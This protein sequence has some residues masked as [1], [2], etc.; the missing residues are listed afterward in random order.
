MFRSRRQ[1]VSG[2]LA[3]GVVSVR[4][5]LGNPLGK[6]IGLQLYM[7]DAELGKDFDG[8][9]KK[10]ARIGIKEVE[11]A[12]TYGK[13]AGEWKAALQKS[14]LHC[15]SVHV[16]D[17][18]QA[19]EDVMKF[20][21]EL[22]ARYVVTSLNAPPAVLAKIPKGAPLDWEHLVHAV[23][24]MTAEDWKKSAGMANEL[25]AQ[26][27][28][29]GLTYAYHNH[30]VEFKKFGNTTAYEMLLAETDPAKVKFEMDC[31]WVA[32]AGYDPAK[33]LEK[34]PE[35]LRL[36]HIK[37]FQAGAANLNLVGPKEPKPTEVGRGQPHYKPVFDAA[38]AHAQV[39]QYYL[40]QEPPYV[41]M[42]ALAAV[43]A[44]YEYLHGLA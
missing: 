9:L 22:G 33:F 12:A 23:E 20:A 11:I 42:T 19:P 4:S 2:L 37:A 7:V 3:A 44:G 8:T 1:F 27:A 16:F 24:G 38:A 26:A 10:V 25:G 41:D 28:K 14:G 6:P 17:I 29:H 36:L 39:E 5:G 18:T 13:S 15:R 30:N 32:A 43:Q 35:R 34:Y 40:E 21:A 31:G